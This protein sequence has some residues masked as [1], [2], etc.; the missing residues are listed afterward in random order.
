MRPGVPLGLLVFLLLAG[1]VVC[2]P[3][4]GA[5]VG[6]GATRPHRNVYGAS[7][8]RSGCWMSRVPVVGLLGP[9]EQCRTLLRLCRMR[10]ALGLFFPNRW[11]PSVLST[12]RR[13]VR[14]VVLEVSSGGSLNLKKEWSKAT[15]IL[16]SSSQHLLART[17]L[18]GQVVFIL[19]APWCQPRSL[20]TSVQHPLCGVL[21]LMLFF[22]HPFKD[23]NQSVPCWT[24]LRRGSR[25]GPR[26]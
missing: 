15:F 13:P 2:D 10:E 21:V 5:F 9:R 6:A 7:Q 18:A 14:L 19:V 1:L 4:D 26:R 12:C 24:R 8:R 23:R 20:R 3:L 11:F 17:S 25:P 16:S 22:V